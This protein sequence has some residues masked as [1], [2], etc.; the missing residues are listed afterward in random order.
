MIHTSVEIRQERGELIV[1]NNA[2]SMDG[3][4]LGKE[5]V[6]SARVVKKGRRKG[7]DDGL[8]SVIWEMMLNFFHLGTYLYG[9]RPP[10]G[11]VMPLT[12]YMHEMG[13]V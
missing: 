3:S 13:G 10:L 1:I 8:N 2:R 6:V 7:H 12:P 9:P 4:E 11:L 5:V